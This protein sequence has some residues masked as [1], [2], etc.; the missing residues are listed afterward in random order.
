MVLLSHNES[1][2]SLST[3]NYYYGKDANDMKVF[4]RMYQYVIKPCSV[5]IHAIFIFFLVR[6]LPFLSFI[7]SDVAVQQSDLFMDHMFYPSKDI[8]LD[9]IVK[10]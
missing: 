5:V 9:I 7:D 2:A 6:S 1:K 10:L 4:C 8:A 3:Y